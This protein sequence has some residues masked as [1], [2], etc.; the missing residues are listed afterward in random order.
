MDIN[1]FILFASFMIVGAFSMYL[2]MHTSVSFIKIGTLILMIA[3][4]GMAF[5]VA[6][7]SMIA[8]FQ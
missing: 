8:W 2:N 5:S 3:S 1:T 6:V 4:V 7:S